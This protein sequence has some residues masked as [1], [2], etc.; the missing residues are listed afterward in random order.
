[1]KATTP[2]V[3]GGQSVTVRRLDSLDAVKAERMRLNRMQL[4]DAMRDTLSDALH[5]LVTH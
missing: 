5:D 3:T 2:K 1:M 4:F